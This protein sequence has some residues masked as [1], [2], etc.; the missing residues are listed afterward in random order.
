MAFQRGIV[1]FGDVVRSREW[2]G[3]T[4]AWL[5]QLCRELDTEYADEQLAGFEF[6]QGDEIQGLLDPL[7]DPFRAIVSAALRPSEEVPEMRWAIVAGEVEP[8][9]GPATRRSGPAFVKARETIEL[10][11][12]QRDTLLVHSGDDPTDAI[13]EG[14]APVLGTM[15]VHLRDRQ[16]VIARLALYEKLRQSEVADR[17]GIRRATISVA[18][19]R[20]DVRSLERLLGA[21]R[22][23]WAQG[24]AATGSSDPAAAA[25][26]A[27]SDP[28]TASSD[29]GA[30]AGDGI[31]RP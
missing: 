19:T 4:A 21:V 6:T 2:P 23:L 27:T 7:A 30:V 28:G 24:M 1:L 12:H 11:R 18:F 15:M 5:E 20:A 26:T 3:P 29:P 10:A 22:T 16:R 14:T 9:H 31:A 17:L 8:G 25:A 13:L